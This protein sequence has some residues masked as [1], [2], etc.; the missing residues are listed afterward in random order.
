[1]AALLAFPSCLG[2]L[3]SNELLREHVA[4]L[5][6]RIASLEAARAASGAGAACTNDGDTV[7]APDMRLSSSAPVA[8]PG[9][10]RAAA[11]AV[12]AAPPRAAAARGEATPR[13]SGAGEPDLTMLPTGLLA[14]QQPAGEAA[15]AASAVDPLAPQLAQGYALLE[16]GQR[17]DAAVVWEVIVAA[18]PDW[19]YGHYYHA[20]ASG[21]RAAME[22][23]ARL[24]ARAESG[25]GLPPEG[26]LYHALV[27]LFLQDAAGAARALDAL[28]AGQRG[29][30]LALGPL[31]APMTMPAD[32][33]R[34]LDALKQ[35][36]VLR[37]VAWPHQG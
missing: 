10:S 15:P 6:A 11:P 24:F 21:Q 33:R 12:T 22:Q 8:A 20:L 19:P 3:R 35:L 27:R 34:R 29:Q 30:Q 25:Q 32:C 13:S 23:A 1:M 36:P 18:R 9:D 7:S 2:A 16:G 28:A 17:R 26:Q 31:Y 37:Q 4:D 14:R 5:Q